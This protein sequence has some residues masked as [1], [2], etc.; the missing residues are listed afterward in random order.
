MGGHVT[1]LNNAGYKRSSAE[2]LQSNMTYYLQILKPSKYH[3]ADAVTLATRRLE[4]KNETRA[5]VGNF[6][7]LSR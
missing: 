7:H 2:K 4:V 1:R 5:S 6:G 3:G